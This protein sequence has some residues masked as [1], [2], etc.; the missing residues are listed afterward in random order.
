MH[1]A[2]ILFGELTNKDHQQSGP[3][4]NR[5]EALALSDEW[6]ECPHNEHGKECPKDGL[7]D[8]VLIRP[9]LLQYA[10]LWSAVCMATLY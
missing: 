3:H 10:R 7:T 8:P 2:S 9:E 5:V 6:C 1:H 4:D